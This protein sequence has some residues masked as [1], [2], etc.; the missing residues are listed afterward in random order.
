MRER[1]TVLETG[2]MFALIPLFVVMFFDALFNGNLSF[3]EVERDIMPVASVEDRLNEAAIESN[4]SIVG[5]QWHP[6]PMSPGPIE[7]TLAYKLSDDVILA[8]AV[9]YR[10]VRSAKDH[11]YVVFDG[12]WSG[13]TTSSAHGAPI[14][15]DPRRLQEHLR[16]VGLDRVEIIDLPGEPIDRSW[17]SQTTLELPGFED[18]DYTEVV[19]SYQEFG[20]IPQ[21]CGLVLGIG[22]FVFSLLFR[23]RDETEEVVPASG[24]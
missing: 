19:F 7:V 6:L 10:H 22:M 15:W 23:G 18:G 13:R 5:V 8:G 1:L 3:R 12:V 14:Q 17:L 2:V 16:A 11:V 4:F 21:L 20:G 24:G 9:R